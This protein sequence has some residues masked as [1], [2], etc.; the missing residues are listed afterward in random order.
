MVSWT[1]ARL[2]VM[3]LCANFVLISQPWP[4]LGLRP[5]VRLMESLEMNNAKI[6][7]G[8]KSKI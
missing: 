2:L 6:V 7:F 5:L 8:F 1:S 4:V 3:A